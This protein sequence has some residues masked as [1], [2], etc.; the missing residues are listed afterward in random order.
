MSIAQE[1]SA[2]IESLIERKGREAIDWESLHEFGL[3]GIAIGEELGGVGL[4]A[5]AALPSLGVLAAA[6]V[7]LPLLEG[8]VMPSIILANAE[9]DRAQKLLQAIAEGNALVAIAHQDGAHAMTARQE[10]D[11]WLLS[12]QKI[13]AIGAP[14]ADAII[15]TASSNDEEMIFLIDPQEIEFQ[16]YETM[17]HY[18]AADITLDAFPVPVQSRLHCGAT[19]MTDAWETG[20]AGLCAQ[21]SAIISRLVDDTRDYCLSREQFGQPISSFQTIQHRLV[22]MYIESRR[23]QAA[24]SLITN[25]LEAMSSD[26]SKA[27]NAA[28]VTICD[29]ARFVGQNAVQL[30]GGMGMSDEMPVARLFRKLTA[31]ENTFGTRDQHLQ[32]YLAQ[33]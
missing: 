28:K 31:L 21:A 15:V 9:C 2:S 8:I 14:E 4:S 11:T 22:D 18:T 32:A 25:Q 33:D 29:A 16:P 3:L 19:A 1:L 27:L 10:G 13:L 7:N 23:A 24:M 30:H 5:A 26:R 17:D 6:E 20:V 12:G